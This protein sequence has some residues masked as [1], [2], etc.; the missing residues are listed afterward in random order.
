[1]CGLQN[2]TLLTTWNEF[3]VILAILPVKIRVH[4][5]MFGLYCDIKAVFYQLKVIPVINVCSN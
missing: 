4:L 1:M 5:P 2:S 3:K